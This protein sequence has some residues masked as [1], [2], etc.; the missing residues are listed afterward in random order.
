MIASLGFDRNAAIEKTISKNRKHFSVRLNMSVNSKAPNVIKK[1]TKEFLSA[2][3][4]THENEKKARGMKVNLL[5]TSNNYT[6]IDFSKYSGVLHEVRGALEKL[7]MP[8]DGFIYRYE[9]APEGSKDEWI[10]DVTFYDVDPTDPM[11]GSTAWEL[12]R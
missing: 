1:L 5:L 6:D 12:Y 8:I 3:G 10:F 4:A 7:G 2:F 9:K 11:T